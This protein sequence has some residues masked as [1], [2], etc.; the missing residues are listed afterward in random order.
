[1]GRVHIVRNGQDRPGG[2]L[3]PLDVCNFV[4]VANVVEE[5]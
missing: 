1:M 4:D 2:V 5:E 3:A